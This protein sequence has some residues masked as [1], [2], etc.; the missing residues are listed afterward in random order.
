MP[1]DW[2]GLRTFALVC[3]AG[4]MSAAARELG[5]NQT[6]VARRIA[7]L[8]EWV[9]YSVL[10]RDG[11]AVT[12]TARAQALLQTALQ[13]QET[14]SGLLVGDPQT[15]QDTNQ[16]SGIVRLTGVDAILQDCVAPH[17]ASL[18]RQYPGIALELIGAN[19]NLSLP[20]RETDIAIRLARP[21]TGAFHIRRLGCLEYGVFCNP[22]GLPL[23]ALDPTKLPWIDL[24]EFFADKPEQKWLADHFPDRKTIG[25]ANRGSIMVSM[26]AGHACCALLPLCVGARIDGLTLLDGYHPVGREVWLLTHQDKR[27]LPPVRAVADWLVDVLLNG[28]FISR[29]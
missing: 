23:E 11:R 5:I 8:E 29:L 25:Y 27:H 22:N 18:H 3:Q 12:P 2:E 26:M 19:R 15:D 1:L 7:R 13:M 20:Q 16:I 28:E 24:D 10:H 17:M 21:E 9:G 14:V 6:T 4:N